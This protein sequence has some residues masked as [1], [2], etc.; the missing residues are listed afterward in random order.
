M[1]YKAAER[2]FDDVEFEDLRKQ[3]DEL[4][5]G[6]RIV[7]GWN[8][9]EVTELDAPDEGA[10]ECFYEVSLARPGLP[11]LDVAIHEYGFRTVETLQES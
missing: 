2:N 11:A 1:S 4:K 7:W 10:G 3:I 8:E 6:D 5:T 9:Y